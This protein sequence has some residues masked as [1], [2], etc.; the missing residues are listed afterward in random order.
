MQAGFFRIVAK[1]WINRVNFFSNGYK[2]F[3]LINFLHDTVI[4]QSFVVNLWLII[5][6]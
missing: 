5:S 4:I 6:I 3:L 2:L 1:C